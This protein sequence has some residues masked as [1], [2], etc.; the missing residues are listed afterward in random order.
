MPVFPKTFLPLMFCA[1][2]LYILYYS[3]HPVYLNYSNNIKQKVWSWTS[4]LHNFPQSFVTLSLLDL[5]ED[6]LNL[7]S[8]FTVQEEMTIPYKQKREKVWRLLFFH[9]QGR[10]KGGSRWHKY[11]HFCSLSIMNRYL[12]VKP[13]NIASQHTSIFKVTTVTIPPSQVTTSFN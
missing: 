5:Y 11:Q 2:T 1:K 6:I 4:S 13:V 8:Y 9:L 7:W 10:Y 3:I 12:T